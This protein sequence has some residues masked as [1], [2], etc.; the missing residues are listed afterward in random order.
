MI[1]SALIVRHILTTKKMKWREISLPNAILLRI[2]IVDII[3]SFFVYF[4]SFWMVPKGTPHVRFASGTDGT[5]ALQGWSDIFSMTYFAT[6]YTQS[7]VL[8]WLIVT[9][10]WTKEQMNQNRIR[11]SFNLPPILAALCFSIPPLFLN[12]YN[13]TNFYCTLHGSP[14]AWNTEAAVYGYM[15]LGNILVAIFMCLLVC[16]VYKQEKKSDKYLSKGQDKNRTN[17]TNTSWQG[18]RFAAAYLIPYVMFYLIFICHVARVDTKQLST[19]GVQFV[20][21]WL[22]IITPMLGVF[23]AGVYFWPRYQAHRKQHPE[24]SRMA[25]L[26]EVLG[27][28]MSWCFCCSRQERLPESETSNGTA[29]T[30]LITSSEEDSDVN[31]NDVL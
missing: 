15:L 13:P 8:Y 31:I 25:G 27:I 22:A 7:S 2:S 18:V 1:G 6:A 26:L 21:A 5:C 30:P 20:G 10:G 4:L 3:A 24:Q 28:D 16:H 17:T 14:G 23:N 19:G 12:F 11:W 29:S 9:K